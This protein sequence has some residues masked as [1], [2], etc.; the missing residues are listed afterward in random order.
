[1]KKL[2]N[3]SE[4]RFIEEQNGPINPLPAFVTRTT[5]R[6]ILLRNGAETL[7]DLGIHSAAS[8]PSELPV[9]D[10]PVT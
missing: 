4:P 10:T 8:T 3:E 6:S 5:L 7:I 2:T 1:M 9:S